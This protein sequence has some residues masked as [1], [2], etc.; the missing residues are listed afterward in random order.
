M[1]VCACVRVC[2]GVC[3]RLQE[4]GSTRESR[5]SRVREERDPPQEGFLW[6]SL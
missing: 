6:E 4:S 1:C 2:I 5:E 3:V